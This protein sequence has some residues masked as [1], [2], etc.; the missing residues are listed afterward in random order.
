MAT[1]LITIP[2]YQVNSGPQV[3]RSVYPYGM[4][5]AFAGASLNVQPNT[6][7]TLNEL[8]AGRQSGGALIYSKII[9]SATG[10][11]VFYSNLTV[12]AI[13]ALANA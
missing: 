4:P 1:V 2:V 13:I 3:D 11:T 10:S 5:V 7:T 12:A 6:G 8:Q 9:S